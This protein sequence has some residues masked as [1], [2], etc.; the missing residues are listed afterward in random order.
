M[1]GGAGVTFPAE[2][3]GLG[4]GGP[5]RCS[6]R[7]GRGKLRSS[8]ELPVVEGNSHKAREA[9]RGHTMKNI[10]HVLRIWYLEVLKDFKERSDRSTFALR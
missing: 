2:I 8:M 9:R 6:G 10:L 7:E 4:A 1:G 3:A 5:G